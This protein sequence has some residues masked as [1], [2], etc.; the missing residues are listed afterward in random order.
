MMD[1]IL[2]GTLRLLGYTIEK[3]LGGMVYGRN[4]NGKGKLHGP[5]YP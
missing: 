3:K 5:L 1:D 2:Y 4:D